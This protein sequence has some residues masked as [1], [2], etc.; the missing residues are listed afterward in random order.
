MHAVAAGCWCPPSCRIANSLAPIDR[1]AT[2]VLAILVDV[3][4]CC[5]FVP[6]LA[7]LV[8]VG[9]CCC[10]PPPLAMLVAMM[11]AGCCCTPTRALGCW[12]CSTA[13]CYCSWLM[14]RLPFV[15]SLV[16]ARAC[17]TDE[18]KA[19]L[20]QKPRLAVRRCGW[21]FFTAR[22]IARRFSLL[23]EVAGFLFGFLAELAGYLFGCCTDLGFSRTFS[24]V[25]FNV[26]KKRLLHN[27]GS[28]NMDEMAKKWLQP[29]FLG[30]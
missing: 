18:G 30:G 21:P 5:P 6:L 8:A 4:C 7:V 23:A 11:V 17:A 9:C 20:R 1:L 10:R 12:C 16:A 3:G 15:A 14:L 22:C 25:F 19:H 27:V 26:H 24:P 28:S 2:M 29:I 13:G